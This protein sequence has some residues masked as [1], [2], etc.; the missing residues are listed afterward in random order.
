MRKACRRRVRGESVPAMVA[1]AAIPE[2]G[3]AELMAIEAMRSGIADY[4]NAY[5]VLADCH[6]MLAIGAK[7]K[8]DTSMQ[9]ILALAE[10]ALRNVFDRMRQTGKVGATGDELM[11]LDLLVEFSTDFWKRQSWD[12]FL[13]AME[14]LKVVRAKQY[15]EKREKNDRQCA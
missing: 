11:A 12:D 10:V 2:I 6:G 4:D 7:R 15:K 13:A 8:R 9:P 5:R 14:I 1:L 3:I